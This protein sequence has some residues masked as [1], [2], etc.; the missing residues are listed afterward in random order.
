MGEKRPSWPQTR[1]V[2]Q[3]HGPEDLLAH[4]TRLFSSGSRRKGSASS[5]VTIKTHHLFA[6]AHS[7]RLEFNMRPS[8]ANKTMS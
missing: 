3:S 1:S 7:L 6:S 4:I 8:Y 2:S 5:S